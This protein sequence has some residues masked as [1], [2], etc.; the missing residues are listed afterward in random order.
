MKKTGLSYVSVLLGRDR[1]GPH[2]TEADFDAWIIYVDAQL[3][4]C[5]GF[6]VVVDGRRSYDAQNDRYSSGKE[7]NAD[8][9]RV[10][11]GNL[12]AEFCAINE[13]IVDETNC[14]FTVSPHVGLDANGSRAILVTIPEANAPWAPNAEGERERDHGHATWP[15]DERI[16][17]R[18]EEVLGVPLTD[19]LFFWDTGGNLL[20]AVY[21]V[22]PKELSLGEAVIAFFTSTVDCPQ[23]PP[24]LAGQVWWE[25]SNGWLYPWRVVSYENG[26]AKCYPCGEPKKET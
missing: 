3:S 10:V 16:R 17:A 9:A 6:G 12:W 5:V 15:T 18:A 25:S 21:R 7:E 1:L 20:E 8:L 22:R 19:Y 11:V 2:A 14:P 23:C 13:H 26:V 24:D 4:K